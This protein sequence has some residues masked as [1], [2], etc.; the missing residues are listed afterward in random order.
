MDNPIELK[1]NEPVRI[2]LSSMTEF[3]PVN[4]FHLH[5]GMFNYT[6]SGTLSTPSTLTDIVT[7]GQGDQGIIEFTPRYTG[8]M[9]IHAH[10]NE[11]TNL[12]WMGTFEVVD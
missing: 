1:L 6:S 12:G 5:S 7:I 2:Y 3:D 4:S 9:M 8:K 10:I 11:F